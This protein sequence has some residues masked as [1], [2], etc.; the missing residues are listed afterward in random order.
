MGLERERNETGKKTGMRQEWD[1]NETGMG[2]VMERKGTRKLG[3][4]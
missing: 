4:K 2:Q 3:R 1:S